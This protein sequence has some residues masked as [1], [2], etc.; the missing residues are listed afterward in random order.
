MSTS[1][2][3]SDERKTNSREKAQKAQKK[4]SRRIATRCS[5]DE[6][7]KSINGRS[8]G[9]CPLVEQCLN[10]YDEFG[11]GYLCFFFRSLRPF[12][13]ISFPSFLNRTVSIGR[14]HRFPEGFFSQKITKETKG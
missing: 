1:K 9:G 6:E 7:L 8:F 10:A 4:E 3:E 5:H 11:P 13:A 12:A 2:K 14:K